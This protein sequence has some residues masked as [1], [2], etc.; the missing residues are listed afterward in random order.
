M[1]IA[2]N[3]IQKVVGMVPKHLKPIMAQLEDIPGVEGMTEHERTIKY[4]EVMGAQPVAIQ[5]ELA[6][7]LGKMQRL[8]M[9]SKQ[10]KVGNRAQRRR[11]V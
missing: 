9:E 11:R 10:P 2:K 6:V 4:M 5:K 7:L 1:F 8:M 3:K